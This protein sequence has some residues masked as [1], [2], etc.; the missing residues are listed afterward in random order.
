MWG[1]LRDWLKAEGGADIPDLDSLH[2]DVCG[3]GYSYDMHQRLLLE[4]KEHMRVDILQSWGAPYDNV[5]LGVS[6]GANAAQVDEH[7]RGL[8][9]IDHLLDPIR[10]GDRVDLAPALVLLTFRP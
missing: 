2:A 3:P 8:V 6:P 7:P 5:V 9:N 1:R 4:S 10:A